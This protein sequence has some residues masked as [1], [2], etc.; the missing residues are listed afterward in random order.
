MTLKGG[1]DTGVNCMRNHF[2]NFALKL[3]EFIAFLVSL[4]ICLLRS[5]F[6]SNWFRAVLKSLSSQI[7]TV[8]LYWSYSWGSWGAHSKIY[9]QKVQ[10]QHIF[11]FRVV[12][13]NNYYYLQLTA[14]RIEMSY[15]PSLVMYIPTLTKTVLRNKIYFNIKV[16]G[17]AKDFHCASFV[18]VE[19]FLIFVH[20]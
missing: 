20:Y 5:F 12:F 8:I 10:M 2:I 1:N 6:P 18:A 15:C 19:K 14:H 13:F 7:S 4:F 16:S 17:P 3:P 9:Y 11:Y